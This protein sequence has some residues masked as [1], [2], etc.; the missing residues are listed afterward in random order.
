MSSRALLVTMDGSELPKDKVIAYCEKPF[1]IFLIASGVS[2]S[3][4]ELEDNRRLYF[5][6]NVDETHPLEAI[7]Y[8]GKPLMIDYRKVLLAEEAWKNAIVMQKS[9]TKA[10]DAKNA[11]STNPSH[12]TRSVQEAIDDGT[13]D[14]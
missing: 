9:M 4:I 13:L 6:F 8:T 2:Y 14:A 7:F 5:I 12:A 3:R 11:L 10:L 1:V